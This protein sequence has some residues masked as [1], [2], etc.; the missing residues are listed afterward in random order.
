[1]LVRYLKYIEWLHLSLSCGTT[2]ICS[3]EVIHILIW[4]KY[5]YL[6]NEMSKYISTLK[7]TE[8]ILIIIF[9]H[10][11][12]KLPMRLFALLL[13]GLVGA[14]SF[15]IVPTSG[16]IYSP[17]RVLLQTCRHQHGNW[18]TPSFLWQLS[19]SHLTQT[20]AHAH[21]SIHLS[22]DKHIQPPPVH[23]NTQT[24]NS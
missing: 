24:P 1:M 23:L 18:R 12:S 4:L 13:S 5:K 2:I 17:N 11:R 6:Y 3:F 14:A 21:T 8:N 20:H 22:T 7:S 9:P 19:L 16:G 15:V 10:I